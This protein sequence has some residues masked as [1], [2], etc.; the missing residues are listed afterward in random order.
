MNV[1]FQ[2]SDLGGYLLIHQVLSLNMKELCFC[3]EHNVD[4]FESSFNNIYL[5]P[6]EAFLLAK[7]VF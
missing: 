1:S 7:T 6:S 2:V 5:V 4:D 3:C